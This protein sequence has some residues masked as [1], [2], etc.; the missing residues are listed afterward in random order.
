MT[1]FLVI[2]I[3]NV[4][5][6]DTRGNRYGRQDKRK[7]GGKKHDRKELVKHRAKGKGKKALKLRDNTERRSLWVGEKCFICI[8]YCFYRIAYFDTA[9]YSML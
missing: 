9:D 6:L 2:T 3:Y 8:Q 5:Q 7:Q 4:C 1:S